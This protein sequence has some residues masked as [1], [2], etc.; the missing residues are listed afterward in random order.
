MIIGSLHE[1]ETRPQS[2]PGEVN[3]GWVASLVEPQASPAGQANG[4]GDTPAGLLDFRGCYSLGSERVDGFA[5]IV[6]HEI[7]HASEQ[8]LVRMVLDE[9][10]VPGMNP[11]FGGRQGK[12]QPAFSRI[13]GFEIENVAEEG[14]F[15][16]ANR[17]VCF[18]D[19]QIPR[20]SYSC[21]ALP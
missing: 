18:G 2:T 21:L 17:R 15:C 10:A 19:L 20:W 11:Q 12:D 3:R 8:L 7:D 5:Q 13:N 9:F 6:A 1:E 4:C 16:L 14:A